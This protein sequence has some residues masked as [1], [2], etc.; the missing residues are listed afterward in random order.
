M[1]TLK[2]VTVKKLNLSQL[3]VGSAIEGTFQGF[4][5]GDTFVK[6]GEERRMLFATV[7][8]EAGDRV[9]ATANIG[10][11]S[12]L[13]DAGISEG[14]WFRAV[15]LPKENISGGRTMNAYDVYTR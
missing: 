9:V 1:S 10:F 2:K 15:K 5:H 13:K 12:A 3:E 14:N 6:N 8:D 7:I 11:Q 4:F